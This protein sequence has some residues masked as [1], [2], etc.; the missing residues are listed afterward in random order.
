MRRTVAVGVLAA[1]LAGCG[2][3]N[4]REVT[5]TG[6]GAVASGIIENQIGDSRG[7][8]IATAV[9]A[10]PWLRGPEPRRQGRL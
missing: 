3:D 1:V 7:K 10:V 5:G 6:L 4:V 8:T 9:G 2:A